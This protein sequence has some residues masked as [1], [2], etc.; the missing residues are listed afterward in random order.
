MCIDHNGMLN[1]YDVRVF[2]SRHPHVPF[3]NVTH[4]HLHTIDYNQ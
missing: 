2:M 1:L 3:R 4:F